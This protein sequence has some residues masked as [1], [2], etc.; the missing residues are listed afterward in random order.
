[1]SYKFGN[2]DVYKIYKGSTLVYDV[3]PEPELQ[4]AIDR[5]ISE[6]KTLLTESK[7]NAY[8][9]LIYD[10]KTGDATLWSAFKYF[11]MESFN[12]LTGRDLSLINLKNPTG[13]KAIP[14]GDA[15][16]TLNGWNTAGVNG[17]LDTGFNMNQL[18][19]GGFS[20]VRGFNGD[21]SANPSTDEGVYTASPT[22]R[23]LISPAYGVNS[24]KYTLNN[25][26]ATY[27]AGANNGIKRLNS[28]ALVG[29][30]KTIRRNNLT[31]STVTSAPISPIINGNY[32]ENAANSSTGG[33]ANYTSGTSFFIAFGSNITDA[34]H[35]ILIEKI[36]I[37]LAK[38]GLT[39]IDTATL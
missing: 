30:N 13:A 33:V 29:S 16:Y 11:R 20:I 17:Y 32:Y 37:F 1:M 34:Q 7:L 21:Y 4:A 3:T 5:L 24:D 35:S 18:S 10:I 28:Y 8:N 25:T 23:I 27:V 12:D 36:N 2:I 39:L 14:Y 19:L 31:P 26:S 9:E 22:R 15:N 6:G 38:V